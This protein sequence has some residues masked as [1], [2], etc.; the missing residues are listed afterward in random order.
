MGSE[1]CIRDRYSAGLNGPELMAKVES[2]PDK[3]DAVIAE[4]HTA[5]EN[6]D[7]WGV[8]LMTFRGETFYGQ[9]RIETLL[10]R[11]RDEGLQER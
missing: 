8:P 6:T 2:E 9:D 5:Q 7:H 10:W 4:N 11:M 1:M 3:L